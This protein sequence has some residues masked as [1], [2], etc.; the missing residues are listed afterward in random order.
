MKRGIK[1]NVSSLFQGNM[2]C[3]MDCPVAEAFDFQEHML[4]C[5]RLLPRLY[6]TQQDSLTEVKYADIFGSLEEQK[7]IVSIF[8]S[9]LNIGQIYWRAY[10]WAQT[11]DLSLQLPPYNCMI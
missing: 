5:Q 2:K 4:I 10:Q 11:L 6:K 7:Q 9:M 1:N 8:D 3:K